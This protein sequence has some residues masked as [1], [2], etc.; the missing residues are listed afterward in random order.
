MHPD[1]P[2]SAA[3]SGQLLDVA[4]GS[5]SAFD[6]LPVAC[7]LVG[8]DLQVLWQTP[9]L[10]EFV[11][12]MA[13]GACCESLGMRHTAA[14]C[15]S[16]RTLEQRRPQQRT[17]WLGR[18]QLA[19][20]TVPVRC[21]DGGGIG[22]LEFFRNVTSEKK[23]EG[24]L[25][26]QQ[27]LLETINRSMIEIN[28]HLEAAQAELEEKNHCLEQANEQLRSL[29]QMKDD[30]LSIVSHELKAPLTSIKASVSLIAGSEA[31]K[32]SATGA[33]LLDVCHRSTE[34]L[35]RLVEDLLDVTRIESGHLSL[36]FR[37]FSA[38]EMILECLRAVQ[39]LAD[40]KGLA[41]ECRA[42]PDFE[43]TADR[44]RL[45]QVVVNLVNN[46]IKFTEHGAVTVEASGAPNRIEFR[47]RD[48]GIGIPEESLWRVF[49][50]FTQVESSLRRNSGGT[51]LGL[52]IV[53]GIIREHGGDIQVSSRVNEGSCFTFSIPQ[54]PGKRGDG[55]ASPLD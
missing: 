42:E 13:G 54:P 32:L 49:D 11:K 5:L 44:D 16:T 17:L 28:H 46:A 55:A 34:R 52:A 18:L 38:R 6:A 40:E 53:R 4:F 10:T 21:A 45:I 36:G 15:V 24:A 31:G 19:V 35:H 43:I 23:L 22:S 48:T 33:E 30:F 20:E 39:A 47:V 14:D 27:E 12:H 25:I 51:G 26:R 29:D 2:A 37:R 41:L 7:R 3:D 8:S 1:F 9:R 50:K